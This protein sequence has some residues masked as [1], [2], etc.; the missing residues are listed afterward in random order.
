[1][2]EEVVSPTA[3][4]PPGQVA[5]T[6][7]QQMRRQRSISRRGLVNHPGDVHVLRPFSECLEGWVSS[8]PTRQLPSAGISQCQ[9]LFIRIV[10]ANAWF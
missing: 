4:A 5:T 7:V 1:M 8:E 9:T 2:D 3:E 6:V 10:A